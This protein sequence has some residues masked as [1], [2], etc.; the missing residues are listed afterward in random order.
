M[1][2]KP[3]TILSDS[4]GL[5]YWVF[6]GIA[7]LVHFFARGLADE[8]VEEETSDIES[9]DLISQ[10]YK[11]R[12]KCRWWIEIA[13]KRHAN[14]MDRMAVRALKRSVEA[15]GKSIHFLTE[16]CREMNQKDLIAALSQLE[17]PEP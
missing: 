3:N 8:L 10:A 16:A 7:W 17:V 13:E 11:W 15:R 4:G 6:A 2:E 5:I 1:K 14:G 9:A 12:R